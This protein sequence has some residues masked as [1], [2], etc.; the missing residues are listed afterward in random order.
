MLLQGLIIRE[1][2]ICSKS[3]D[4]KLAD[5]LSLTGQLNIKYT[6][7]SKQFKAKPIQDLILKPATKEK[8]HIWKQL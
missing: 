4:R 7:K 2:K 1:L 5:H 3:D 6:G 8:N